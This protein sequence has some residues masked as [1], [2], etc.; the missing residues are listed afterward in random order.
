MWWLNWRRQA[1]ASLRKS[2]RRNWPTRSYVETFILNNILNWIEY[3]NP[4]IPSFAEKKA[5]YFVA[6]G[7]QGN[8]QLG[9]QGPQWRSVKIRKFFVTRILI[10]KIIFSC[11]EARMAAKLLEKKFGIK[12]VSWDNS[13]FQCLEFWQAVSR[14]IFFFLSQYFELWARLSTV[15]ELRFFTFQYLELCP[16]LWVETILFFQYLEL[17]PG[18]AL[19]EINGHGQWREAELQGVQPVPQRVP[20]DHSGRQRR[21]GKVNLTGLQMS[22]ICF[23]MMTANCKKLEVVHPLGHPD[24]PHHDLLPSRSSLDV[25]KLGRHAVGNK[26]I[27][28]DCKQHLDNLHAPELASNAAS[29]ALCHLP[30]PARYRLA[31]KRSCR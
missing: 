13:P 2:Q 14:K 19:D 10:L 20:Q 27:C 3:P 31:E 6:L 25:H 23:Q 4:Q 16:R 30:Q 9:W 22:T 7:H 28:C 11:Q 8:F 29:L 18:C 26:H 1:G 5:K 12:D 24:Q 17:C 15:C 21:G